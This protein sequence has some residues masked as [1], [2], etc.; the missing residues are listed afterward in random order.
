ML[1][2]LDARPGQR[3]LD[4]GSGSGWTT[5]LLAHLVGPAG[6]VRGVELVPELVAFARTRVRAPWA[7]IV[8]AVPGRL[9]L[10]DGAPFDRLLVSADAGHI[11]DD[12]TRQLAAGG[13]MVLPADGLMW[14]VSRTS[15]GLT[16]HRAPGLF[17]F[18]PLR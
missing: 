3:V 11:P 5:Q 17:R 10:P 13:R 16:R 12:L 7:S 18:V 9:G 4:V 6:A 2:L 14:V 15:H 8:Q 1:R